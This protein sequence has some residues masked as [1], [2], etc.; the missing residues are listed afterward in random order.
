MGRT[1][2][3]FKMIRLPNLMFVILTQVL[4][5]FAIF[6]PIY[7]SS[8]PDGDLLQFILLVIA[9]VFIAAG[10]YIIN[11]YFDI[12]IDRVNKPERMVV[13][14]T[15]S[16]R[17]ALAWHFGLSSLGIFI[18]AI[19]VN[20]FDRW[21]LVIANILAVSLLWFYSARFKRDVLIGNII[22]SLLTAWTI[23][24]IFLSKFSFVDAFSNATLEQLKLFR[25]AVLYSG[26]AFMINLV[27]EAIKDM[28]D[29]AGDAK[30]GCRTMPIVWGVNATKIY[31]AVWLTILI[32]MLIIIQVYVMQFGWWWA[33]L[34]CFIL[35]I[36]PLFVLFNK[37]LK[38]KSISDYS[39]LSS[40]TKW[41]M[42]GGILSMLMFYI[43]L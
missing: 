34:Y 43:Y 33:V 19:A 28:E 31:T 4:F 7:G 2:A 10:G 24:I 11:D 13:G 23:M 12:D 20:A 41:I 22:I 40:L 5:Q 36:V 39:Y 8:V 9:S 21:Y 26:F 14:K 38:A 6:Y 32:G 27:R 37:L 35:V 17:T 42:L 16:R 1:A 3:F 15:I 18:T 25:F 30:Y 29:V